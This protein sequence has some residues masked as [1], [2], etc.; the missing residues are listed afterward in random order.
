MIRITTN[1]GVVKST[2][3][4]RV[5]EVAIDAFMILHSVYN[6][7]LGEDPVIANW[8]ADYIKSAINSEEDT[9]FQVL[10]HDGEA[11]V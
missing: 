8:F 9:P 6:T 1:K 7:L 5:G 10:P 11:K 3:E 2:V 4:G